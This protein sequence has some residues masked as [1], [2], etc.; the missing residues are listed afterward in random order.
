MEDRL[1]P[2][3]FMASSTFL[4]KFPVPSAKLTVKVLT[5]FVN[6]S[7]VV[8]NLTMLELVLRFV[9]EKAGKNLPRGNPC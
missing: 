4:Y 7:K 9:T 1:E 8:R 2:D 6:I 3:V 5:R